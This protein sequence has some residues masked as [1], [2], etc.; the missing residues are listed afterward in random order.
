MRKRLTAEDC[1]DLLRP[2][3]ACNASSKGLQTLGA[4]LG[5]NDC[6]SVAT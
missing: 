5:E 6:P 3:I 2:V 1:T 4:T